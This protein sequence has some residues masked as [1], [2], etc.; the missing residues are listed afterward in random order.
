MRSQ[1]IIDNLKKYVNFSDAELDLFFQL[2]KREVF[3]KNK[4]LTLAG[5]DEAMLYHVES[6]CLMSY[7]LDTNQHK[8][9]L[10][11]STD[12]WWTGDLEALCKGAKCSQFIRTSDRTIVFTLS[13]IGYEKL[14]S[15][16][17]NFEKYFRQLFQNSIISHQKRIIRNIS[18]SAE[19]RYNN[20]IE[21]SW[22][23]ARVFL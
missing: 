9:V 12:L 17:P 10:Q 3:E 8:H 11:F 21:Q 22:Y 16:S 23:N 14:L 18:F 1:K 19:E 7:V 20:F 13:S 5:D 15:A 2:S 6:G 4:F